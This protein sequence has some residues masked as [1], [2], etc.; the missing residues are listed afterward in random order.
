MARQNFLAAK[1]S[2]GETVNNFLPVCR[3]SRNVV[4]TKANRI[5]RLEIVQFLSQ[6]I[7]T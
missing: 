6:K 1:P 7:E 5:T 3:N 2:A 4:T